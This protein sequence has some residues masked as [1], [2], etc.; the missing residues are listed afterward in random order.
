MRVPGVSGSLDGKILSSEAL[1]RKLYVDQDLEELYVDQ[2]LACAALT[3]PSDCP[4]VHIPAVTCIVQN[5]ED[6]T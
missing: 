4:L 2:A 5:V 1:K 3:T 6:D